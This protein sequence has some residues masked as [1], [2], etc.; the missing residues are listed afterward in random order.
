MSKYTLEYCLENKIAVL[1][2]TQEIWD[3]VTAHIGKKQDWEDTWNTYKE[4]S[5]VYPKTDYCQYGDV[6][7]ANK[8]I[9][10]LITVEEYLN[11]DTVINLYQIC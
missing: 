9:Y 2:P 11:E 5:V 4:D 1:C 10:T 8:E 6:D 7:Y 3:K